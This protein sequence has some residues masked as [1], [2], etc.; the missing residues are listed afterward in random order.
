MSDTILK[1]E[2]LRKEYDIVTPLK[3]VNCE[4]KKGDV[5]SIIGPSGTGK[6]TLLNM[7]NRMEEP[8]SGS[9]FYDNEDTCLEGYDLTKLR[10][11]V[12]MVFQQ[13]NLFSHLT[14]A[15]N[16]ML[17]P[18][19]LLG[20]S[21]QEAYDTAIELL[22]SVGLKDKALSY[23]SELSGGQQQRVAIVRALAMEPEMILFDEPTSAL[24]P[25]MI[26]EVQYV[27]K[28]LATKGTTMMIVTHEMKFAKEVSNRVFYMDQGIIYE[29]GTP[30]QV[31]DN[32]QKEL[33]QQFIRGLKVINFQISKHV[34][35]EE[36]MNTVFQYSI[37]HMVPMKISEKV[38]LILEEICYGLVLQKDPDGITDITLE[39][40]GQ[41]ESIKLT[42][43]YAGTHYN[44]KNYDD[45]LSHNIIVKL[46]KEAHYFYDESTSTNIETLIITE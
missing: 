31:F 40:S 18:V 4:I 44:K 36:M 16:I 30:E 2:H 7:I 39:Y 23:P 5:I 38:I 29:E 35:L 41:D 21:R 28:N 14:I 10:K 27:I 3:D 22:D 1:L 33:T 6:S 17:G 37:K 13:W 8:T 43:K 24:D 12:G 15:E 46:A 42:A 32:P 19:N 9:V 34:V 26:A 11:K 25:S 45:D 20:K